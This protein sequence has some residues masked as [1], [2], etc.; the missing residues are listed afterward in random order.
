MIWEKYFKTDEV[1]GS[2]VCPKCGCRVRTIP[3]EKC[4]CQT[5]YELNRMEKI[6][7]IRKFTRKEKKELRASF[8]KMLNSKQKQIT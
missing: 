8:K 5:I 1:I 6:P 4:I 3:G 7:P 2:T